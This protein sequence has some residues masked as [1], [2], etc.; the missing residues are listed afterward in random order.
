[1]SLAGDEH[2]AHQQQ[3]PELYDT[4]DGDPIDW[5][6]DECGAEAGEECR[7]ACTAD[8]GGDLLE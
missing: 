7:P 1:M 5:P 3:H 8:G 2:L 6:C 4:A